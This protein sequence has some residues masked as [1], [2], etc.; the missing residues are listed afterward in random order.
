MYIAV[1]SIFISVALD[2]YILILRYLYQKR[3][4][5]ELRKQVQSASK[6]ETVKEEAKKII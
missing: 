3:D 5:F 6:G 1:M 2:I 4:N